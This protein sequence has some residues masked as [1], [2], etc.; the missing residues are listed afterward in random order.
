MTFKMLAT[1]RVA[2]HKIISN[3]KNFW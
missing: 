2:P 1:S 3:R